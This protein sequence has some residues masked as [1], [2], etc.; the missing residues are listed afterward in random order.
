MAGSN[1]STRLS[2]RRFLTLSGLALAGAGLQACSPQPP[3]SPTSAP[4]AQTPAAPTAAAP[5]PAAAAPTVIPS[6]GKPAGTL[7]W[8]R[9]LKMRTRDPHQVYGLNEGVVLRHV[10]EPLLELGPDGKFKPVLAESWKVSDDG[11]TWTFKLRQGV[12]FHDGTPFNA[13][14]VKAIVER[15]KG[16]AKSGFA[17]MF[18]NYQDT[19]TRIVDA[20]TIEF[21]TKLPEPSVPYNLTFF[22]FPHPDAA[23]DKEMKWEKAI[24]TGPYNLAEFDID[25]IYKLEARTDY[26]KTGFPKIQTLNYRPILEQS[27]LAAAVRAGEFDFVEGLSPDNIAAIAN[28]P[29]FDIVKFNSWRLD[30]LTINQDGPNPAFKD[31]KVRQALA[32]AIDRDVI[33]KDILQGA[34]APW[35]TYP[36][37]GIFGATDKIPA[38]PYD[39]N[40]AQDLM[41]QSGFPNGFQAT[42]VVPPGVGLHGKEKDVAEFV[43]QEVKKLGIQFTVQTGEQTAVQTQMRDGKHEIGYLSS[44]AVTGDPDRYFQ[45]RIVQNVYRAGYKNQTVLD[46]IQKAATTI[47]EKQ[48][49]AL[50]EDIQMKMWNDMPIVYLLQSV[51]QYVKRKKVTGFVG[52]PNQVYNLIETS[53]S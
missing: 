47:D 25:R 53:I 42:L 37:K 32:Y 46:L 15:V 13:E 20:N 16:N 43:A 34:A 49:Q 28:D 41:K 8:A 4:A 14:A 12:K 48:R 45:E 22:L 7:N 31:A 17:F 36:P 21:K 40:K 19:P 39:L 35:S 29:N 3:A 24:G 50:Y 38:N 1:D 44:V 27:S 2:R 5:A 9:T 6:S 26:W 11:L 33:A 51:F 52:M 30:F 18:G 10:M 23:T